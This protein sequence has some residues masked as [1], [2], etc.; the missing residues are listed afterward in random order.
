LQEVIGDVKPFFAALSQFADHCLGAKRFGTLLD[1]RLK[2]C[3][4]RF[5]QVYLYAV[6][7]FVCHFAQSHFNRMWI[8]SDGIL[9]L[10]QK[11]FAV[12]GVFKQSLDAGI[13]RCLD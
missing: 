9:Q 2:H 12:F 4:H 11:L 5:Q 1:S 10:R 8:A 7:Q 13:F 3:L 6:R